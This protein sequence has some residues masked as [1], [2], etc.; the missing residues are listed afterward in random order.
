[1]AHYMIQASYAAETWGALVQNPQ[2]RTEHIGNMLE[3]VGGRL[4]SLYY[5]FGES[6]IVLIAEAPSNVALAS[7]V[8]TVAAGG[9][10]TD[11]KTTDD[12]RRGCRSPHRSAVGLLFPTRLT[13][14]GKRSPQNLQ[15]ANKQAVP[16]VPAV[17]A[18][19]RL[20]NAKTRRG[21]TANRESRY[22]AA[23]RPTSIGEIQPASSRS[24]F[25]CASKS[26]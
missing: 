20:T 6:D 5:T 19:Q 1:M 24:H 3:S 23:F 25:S 11:I 18:R 13:A 2:Q 8:M 22:A 12:R 14:S 16:A 7:I 9:A 15:P 17:P 26:A 21:S 10:A 4:I